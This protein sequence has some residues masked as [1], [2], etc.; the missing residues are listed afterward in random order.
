MIRR[1]V[2]ADG[3]PRTH[4]AANTWFA[5]VTALTNAGIDAKSL[6][7]EGLDIRN[8]APQALTQ[9]RDGTRDWTYPWDASGTVAIANTRVG[10]T[11]YLV[12][13][14]IPIVL[15]TNVELDWSAAPLVVTAGQ[16]LVIE[17]EVAYGYGQNYV[18][19]AFGAAFVACAYSTILLHDAGA[20]Y[21][22]IIGSRF[23]RKFV[24]GSVFRMTHRCSTVIQPGG[25]SVTVKKLGVSIGNDTLA[26]VAHAQIVTYLLKN[27]H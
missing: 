4:T 11:G 18:D 27:S 8:V 17:A 10:G 7:E 19:R 24:N 12:E 26:Y 9:F 14:L 13:P 22:R 20:G 1:I 25:G 3:T 21:T 16:T 23:R 5:D 6:A 2:L 15:G